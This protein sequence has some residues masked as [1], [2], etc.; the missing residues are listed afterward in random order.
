[1]PTTDRTT[2]L[3]TSSLGWIALAIALTAHWPAFPEFLIPECR[4]EVP[5]V[6][7]SSRPA[8]AP[9]AAA[10]STGPLAGELA[11]GPWGKLSFNTIMIEPPEAV[12]PSGSSEPHSQLWQFVGYTEAQLQSLWREA[13]LS[14]ADQEQLNSPEHRTIS[15][16]GIV[17]RPG[18]DLVL[19]L[20]PAARGRIYA[21]LAEFPA[22][23]TQNEPFRFRADSISDWFVD[24]D[25]SPEIVELTNRLLYEHAGIAFFSDQDLVLSRLHTPAERIRYL[26]AL[27]RKPALLIQLNIEH[28]ADAEALAH[29]WGRG[30]RAKDLEPLIASV[31]RRPAGGSL[32]VVHLLPRFPRSMLYTYPMPGDKSTGDAYDCHW[33]SF[34][35]YGEEP[36]DRF[37]DINFVKQTLN[38]DYYPVEGT[39]MMGDI[40]LLVRPGNVVIHSCV[41]V[42]DDIVFT[43]N[44]PG[45]SVPWMLSRLSQ[46]VAFYGRGQELEIR[47]FRPKR[48]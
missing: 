36:D 40:I 42:A 37:T 35:F 11:P 26:K 24:S 2:T 4:A 21:A 45:Y 9:P 28:G 30:R 39:P 16:A 8:V 7:V 34:N 3:R 18:V 38:T 12:I 10:S 31:A 6:A 20:S 27:S 29:Y 44:G 23:I 14:A 47:R 19:A 46:V 25:L 5:T 15:A 32:D 17:V 1:M 48:L 33:T 43:K 13:G 41:F 22:N